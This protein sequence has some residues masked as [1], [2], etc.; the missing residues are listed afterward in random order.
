[1]R[2]ELRSY[3]T[4]G[5]RRRAGHTV[6]VE[7]ET[8]FLDGD[9]QLPIS[10]A[11]SQNMFSELA[12]RNWHIESTRGGLITSLRSERGDMLNYELGRQNLE[13]SA[14]PGIDGASGIMSA[15]VA[16]SELYEVA[17]LFGAAPSFS[18]MLS[19]KEDLLVI[20]DERDA[21]WLQLD[22][23]EA[24]MPLATIS[25]VQFTVEVSLENAIPAINRLN[26]VLP[27]FLREYPQEKVWREYIAQS[28]AGYEESRYG[29]PRYFKSLDDYI[30]Q[31]GKYR[32][33]AGA[34]LTRQVPIEN[35]SLFI[36]SVWW[37]FRLRR[38][39][40]RMCIEVR[41]I[42]R[43]HDADIADKLEMVLNII[44]S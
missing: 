7:A 29:G 2:E 16:L 9:S 32:V 28:K 15:Q 33:V 22:G 27:D 11:T 40:D 12:Q 21:I 25:S 24:L 13:I 44:H 5:L 30:E 35:V 10:L 39:G 23:R 20:P 26:E 43:V 38:Y 42:A 6:G 37:Y 36:R 3:F 18:P 41:P 31:L 19:T 4:D 14:A 34:C 17:R 8:S 1:M